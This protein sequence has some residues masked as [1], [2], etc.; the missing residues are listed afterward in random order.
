MH[1]FPTFHL[2]F[3]CSYTFFL[4][5]FCVNERVKVLIA[6]LFIP[7]IFISVLSTR[8]CY[9]ST[10]NETFRLLVGLILSM[11]QP[12]N[13]SNISADFSGTVCITAWKL[14]LLNFDR[15]G[16][17]NSCRRIWFLWRWTRN[18]HKWQPI[19]PATPGILR[20]SVL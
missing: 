1:E 14:H 17:C 7:S 18:H 5:V 4:C 8:L 6:F 15:R 9:R 12:V 10:I 3:L 11:I 16:S 20:Y 13:I 2:S 19:C